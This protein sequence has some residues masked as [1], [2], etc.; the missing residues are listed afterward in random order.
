MCH[1]VA[2]S[3][4]STIL[5]HSRETAIGNYIT[6][7][8]EVLTLSLADRRT[9]YPHCNSA[10][11]R[12]SQISMPTRTHNRNIQDPDHQL[13]SNARDFYARFKETGVLTEAARLLTDWLPPPLTLWNSSCRSTKRSVMA[14]KLS[15]RASATSDDP[16]KPERGKTLS[17]WGCDE[18]KSPASPRILHVTLQMRF[19]I[20]RSLKGFL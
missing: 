7:I 4:R 11:L 12:V 6:T 1:A 15:S 19:L 20:D 13:H 17:C 2:T 18:D 5:T 3:L 9:M 16:V 14:G 8:G 10:A